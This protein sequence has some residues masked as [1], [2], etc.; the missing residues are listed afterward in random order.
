[1]TQRE[2]I[3]E[4]EIKR[5]INKREWTEDEQLWRINDREEWERVRIWVRMN[6]NEWK[7][8][9]MSENKW[10]MSENMTCMCTK[11]VVCLCLMFVCV[12]R[13]VEEVR[14]RGMSGWVHTSGLKCLCC[15]IAVAVL[16][17]LRLIT[18]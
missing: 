2:E 10:K 17:A 7:W 14:M 1:M 13:W 4:N 9:K 18:C 15:L 16:H 11:Y 12:C 8:M 6:E 5:E 3:R